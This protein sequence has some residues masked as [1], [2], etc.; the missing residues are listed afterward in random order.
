MNCWYSS[1]LSLSKKSQWWSYLHEWFSVIRIFLCKLLDPAASENLLH[2]IA[3]NFICRLIIATCIFT[4]YLGCLSD[5]SEVRPWSRHL[6]RRWPVYADACQENGV[7][8]LCCSSSTASDPP[9]CSYLH[10]PEASSCPGAFQ[11]GLQRVGG[12]SCPPNA[13]TPVGSECSGT[14][15]LR[16]ETLRPH[17]RCT[18]QPSLAAGPGAHTV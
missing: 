3:F 8:L 7:V 6:H 15:D 16:S 18:H 1:S 13:P 5:N 9:I 11:A 2:D 10:I 14:A 17:H 12:Y 4:A